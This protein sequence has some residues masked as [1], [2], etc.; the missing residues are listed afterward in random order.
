MNRTLNHK[1]YVLF[2]SI[3]MLTIYLLLGTGIHG[4]DYTIIYNMLEYD[5]WKYLN[6]GLQ[7]FGG[8]S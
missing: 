1:F 2:V 3:A 7:D 8:R 6:P 5:I 4:D